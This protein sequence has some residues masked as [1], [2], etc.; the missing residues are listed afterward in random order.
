MELAG[1]GLHLKRLLK[2]LFQF[3]RNSE[4]DHDSDC[5]RFRSGRDS[6][7]ILPECYKTRCFMQIIT[8]K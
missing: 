7:T 8:L 1:G 3:L 5:T 4:K 2:K 6:G